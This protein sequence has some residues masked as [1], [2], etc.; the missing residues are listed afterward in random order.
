MQKTIIRL[1]QTSSRSVKSNLPKYSRRIF[2]AALVEDRLEKRLCLTKVGAKLHS[3]ATFAPTF[4]NPP[5][6]PISYP[7]R[8]D[9]SPRRN[10]ER[11]NSCA[12]PTTI[13]P[14]PPSIHRTI[15]RFAESLIYR[16]SF[17]P[18]SLCFYHRLPS[19]QWKKKCREEPMIDFSVGIGVE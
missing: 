1:R 11:R 17:S 12:M 8:I 7:R 5:P 3:P 19:F 4:T 15:A 18:L 16:R 13:H 10:V 6:S 9:A 14:P 2:E